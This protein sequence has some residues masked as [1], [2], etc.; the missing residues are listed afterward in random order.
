MADGL[1]EFEVRAN[2]EKLKS[3][4]DKAE[5]EVRKS[6]RKQKDSFNEI[7]DA[8]EE[9]AE[10]IENCSRENR[11]NLTETADAAEN[12][13]ERIT[14]GN[15]E[16]ERSNESA[17]ESYDETAESASKYS[18]EVDKAGEQAE[19]SAG[20]TDKLSEKVSNL[21]GIV[22]GTAK[23][24]GT[25]IA[26]VAGVA[27]A[28]G[29]YAVNLATDMDTA[30]NSFAASTGIA[31][32]ELGKYQGILENIY[33]N[34]YGEDFLDISDGLS[35]VIQ[36]IG[37]AAEHWD[38]SALQEFTESAYV[39]RDTFG[40][41]I[42]ESIRATD[43]MMEHFCMDGLD[44]MNLIAEG[45][46]NGLDYS[47][48]MIDSIIEYSSQFSKLGFTAEDMFNI[49]QKGADSGAWNLDK[50]G[51]A[52]KEFS[53]RAIDGSDSTKE[54][55]EA[56]GLSADE[57]SAKFGEGGETAKAAFEETVKALASIEDPLK[58]DAAGVALFG[59]MWEDLGPDV[60][61]QLA[62]IEEGAYDTTGA[63]DDIKE[64]KYNDLGSMLEGL[65]RSVE[66]LALPLGEML[67]PA[68]ADLI[69]I[70]DPLVSGGTIESLVS[71]FQTLLTPLLELAVDILPQLVDS[72][73]QLVSS[74]VMP[75]LT[76]KLLP[77]ISKIFEELMPILEQLISGT[78]P[79]LLDMVAQLLPPVAE[80]VAALLPVVL[81]LLESLSEPLASLGAVLLPVLA[82]L[83]IT[84]A[85]LITALMPLIEFLAEIIGGIL[86]VELSL[87]CAYWDILIT[88]IKGVID[89]ISS[90]FQADWEKVWGNVVA[91]VY[92]VLAGDFEDAWNNIVSIFTEIF[93]RIPEIAKSLLNDAIS[94]LNS[95]IDSING[96][97]GKIPGVKVDLIPNIPSFHTGGIIDFKGQYEAPILAKDGEMVLTDVQQK[98]LFDIA[99]G[100][101]TP[102]GNTDNSTNMHTTNVNIEHKN[103][104]TVRDDSDI[105]RIS[106][107]LSEQ[108]TKDILAVGGN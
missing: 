49:F 8:A 72:I 27:V 40:Y 37:P 94:A 61:E 50:V 47:D 87:L 52:V 81:V 89:F 45:A 15:A 77:S 60:V 30:M 88:A 3:D 28:A 68:F 46:Q 31:E 95:S 9:N 44:A 21:G 51:D 74:E 57:M 7:S 102:L 39:L 73:A 48:E 38:D 83:L 10:V 4:M 59:T 23:A 32:T 16:T 104:F 33:K 97:I 98:R 56:I 108:E 55:F 71:S 42:A 58:K 80:L 1:V 66:M 13:A 62:N 70:V 63:F 41:D 29:G 75:L 76:E 82:D 43:A 22:G 5:R 91:F 99:N 92:D 24:V 78:L 86:T 100:F 26:A 12:A 2:T 11:E 105:M 85:E 107:Q 65:K 106:E 35:A 6:A 93:G 25:G 54:G 34:N 90:V 69:E 18:E 64:V 19:K 79:I 103:Y 101:F 17:R 67:I 14:A 36:Q 20:Q 53:I 84:V 96:V